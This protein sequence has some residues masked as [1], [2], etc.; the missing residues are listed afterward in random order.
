MPP[1][2]YRTRYEWLPVTIAFLF[3]IG[4]YWL[5]AATIGSETSGDLARDAYYNR[6]IDGFRAG[7]LYLA[8]EPPA[9]LLAL[10][11]PYDFNANEVARGLSY[12]PNSLHDLSFYQG[13]LYMYFSIVPALILFL[14]YH[15][16][17]GGYIS[18]QYACFIFATLG[19]GAS[20]ALVLSV[21]RRFFPHVRPATVAACSTT[22]CCTR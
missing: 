20:S 2:K 21:R 10:P 4:V 9:S 6:L 12:T 22:A 17:T 15:L 14:P 5:E 18:H 13:K 1:V 19:F 16:L 11:D 7:H 8:K 3:A